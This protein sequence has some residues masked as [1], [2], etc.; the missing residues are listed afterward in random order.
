M[1]TGKLTAL[2]YRAASKNIEKLHLD[3]QMNQLL[4]Y[5]KQ[6]ELDTFLL[7][8]DNGFSGL[9]LDRPALSVLKADIIA[10]RIEKVVV[11]DMS[12]IGRGY[13]ETMRFMNWAKDNGVA[14][15]SLSGEIDTVADI[16]DA[17]LAFAKGGERK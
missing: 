14:I 16:H 15:H 9:T 11:K 17:L 8:A 4:C 12:R 10:G 13:V 2:Y 1:Q 7:Y 5:S 3:N 6:H